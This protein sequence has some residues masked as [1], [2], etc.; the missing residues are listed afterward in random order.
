MRD[1]LGWQPSWSLDDGLAA[2]WEWYSERLA[3]S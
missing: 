3:R 2:T 1:E